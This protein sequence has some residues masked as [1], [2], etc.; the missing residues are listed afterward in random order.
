MTDE[1]NKLVEKWRREEQPKYNDKGEF[2]AGDEDELAA[3]CI[4]LDCAD[5]LAAVL[6]G[7][8]TELATWKRRSEGLADKL[9]ELNLELERLRRKPDPLSEAL[10]MGD[11]SY[12]P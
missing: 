3:S 10:N 11:G 2:I 5:E 9:I 7:I 4:K 6:P 12:K 8:M 1:L